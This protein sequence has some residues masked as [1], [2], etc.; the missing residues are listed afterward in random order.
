[1]RSVFRF[2][3]AMM[4]APTLA[5]AQV[6]GSTPA[7]SNMLERYTRAEQMLPWNTSRSA[8]GGVVAPQ[9]YKDG[10]RFWFRNTTRSGADFIYVDPTVNVQRPLFDNARLAAAITS[11]A[12]TSVDPNKLPFQTFKFAKDNEDERNIEFRAGRKRLTCDIVAY[13]CTAGDTLPS[14]VPFVLSPDKKWE[15]FVMKYNVYVRSRGGS[16][17][18]QLTTDGV[19]W[20]SYGLG[21]QTPQ[22][23]L[24]TRPAPRRPTIRWA[25]DSRHLLVS[26]QDERG[27]LHMPYISYTS[28]RPRIFTQP[29]ALPGDTIVPVPGAHIL[30]R[31]SK[32]NVKIELPVKV[33][34][35][36]LTGSLRDS[37]WSANSATLKITGITRASK[38]AYLW[39]V[40]ADNGKPTLL[41]RDTTKTF[42]EI[43]PPTDPS[44][45]YVT[46]DGQDVI[47]WSERDGWGHLWRYGPDGKV[48]NQITSGP[49]QV[50]KVVNV[51]EKLKQ[52]WFTGRGHEPDHFIYYQ[53]LYRVNFDG[54]G[55]TLLT[56]EDQ[57]HNV[58]VSPSGKFLVDRMS[59]IEKPT[60]VVLREV[61]TGRLVRSLTKTDVSQLGAIGW[62]PAQMFSAKARDGITDV[63]GVIYLPPHLDTTKK[64]P[65]ISHIY[66]GPQVGS[67]GTWDF[68]AGGEPF[69]LAEIGFVVV[70]IDHIG[71]PMRS[72]AFHDQYYGNFHDNG[73]PDH[74]AVLK[75]LAARYPYIDIERVGIFGHSG[76]GFA[77]TDAMLTFPDFFKVAVSGAGNHDN[78]SYNIYW[79]E[80]Y[81]GVLRRDTVAKTDNFTSAANKTYAA[82]LKGHLLLMHGDV[83]DNVH[84][85]NTIQLVDELTKANRN[86]D[87]I[88]APN[89]GH[90]LN[91]PYFIRR[92]WDYF[93][94]WL[95]GQTPP[96]NF[97]ITPPEGALGPDGQFVPDDENNRFM[98]DDES[99][100]SIP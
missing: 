83:D 66:P 97:K 77:S 13:S 72:K 98:R 35:L 8:F 57:N 79:A 71:T 90:G 87:L 36:A 62:K 92:R 58:D 9:W 17:T 2:L 4:L 39:S 7:S 50:G 100:A 11:A 56:P 19:Q 27:V 67:V 32:T 64:Y 94:T 16:D 89:R 23:L 24:A 44:S 74:V 53:A 22:Q 5:L 80:K 61:T 93:V 47:W 30:D 91:E 63:Y 43:S 46:S 29:Y 31:V 73:L 1:M 38:S 15:A 49:W 40:N 70:Q 54:T 88:I 48:K 14:E 59:R 68:K 25:P 78:R 76:G 42:V 81:Q 52:I 69:S 60:E 33:A 84:P 65:I 18:T 85:A 82:N 55:L 26:R 12:D 86:Y 37:V 45:W 51:D 3:C 6:P 21:E 96:E 95:A 28:Q 41:A 10:T 20:W 75:Q 99:A 34:Q